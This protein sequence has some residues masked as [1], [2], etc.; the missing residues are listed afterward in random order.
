MSSIEIKCKCCG[1]KIKLSEQALEEMLDAVQK[2]EYKP[3][4]E[5]SAGLEEL[6]RLFGMKK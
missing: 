3:S 2:Q 1:E 4:G 6:Q 5:S